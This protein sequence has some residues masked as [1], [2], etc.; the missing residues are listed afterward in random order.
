M[1]RLGAYVHLPVLPSVCP[2]PRSVQRT[3]NFCFYPPATTP[4]SRSV[5]RP[6]SSCPHQLTPQ[7]PR[8]PVPASPRIHGPF[9]P[10]REAIRASDHSLYRPPRYK[11]GGFSFNRLLRSN[12]DEIGTSTTFELVFTRN[13]RTV[14]KGGERCRYNIQFMIEAQATCDEQM[15]TKCTHSKKTSHSISGEHFLH[16]FQ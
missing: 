12:L 13:N 6:V 3:R 16:H 8:L 2:N 11:V 5:M 4:A 14:R 15:R 9:I 7:G 1:T 10:D